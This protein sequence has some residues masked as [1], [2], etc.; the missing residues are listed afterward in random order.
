M[1]HDYIHVEIRK[2][3]YGLKEASILA[4]TVL[5]KHLESYGYYPVCYTP[6]LWHHKTMHIL[7]TLVVDDFG[8]K[9]YNKYQVDHLFEALRKNMRSL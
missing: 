6:G 5:V 4:Y 9:F 8:I 2:G 7:F 3:I 1:H